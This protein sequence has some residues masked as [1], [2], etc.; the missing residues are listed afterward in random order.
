MNGRLPTADAMVTRAFNLPSKY[1][2]HVPGP[3]GEK[4]DL[5]AKAYRSVLDGCKANGIRSVAFCCISTGLFGYPA[6]R[7]AQVAVATVR[8]WLNEDAKD[9]ST[10]VDLVIFNTFLESDLA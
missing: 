8:K 4:P 10:S 9:G 5:L 3:V 1:V 7:A 2:I 6:D